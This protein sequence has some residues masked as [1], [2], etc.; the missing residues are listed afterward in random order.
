[1]A[2]GYSGTPLVQKLGIKP[3]SRMRVVNAPSHYLQL[4]GELPAGV[5]FRRATRGAL[6]FVHYFAVSQ[7]DLLAKLPTLKQHLS[8]TGVLWISWPKR[9]SALAH[10]VSE[11]IVREAGLNTGLVD[12]K[13]CAVDEDWS[14]LKFVWRLK[15]R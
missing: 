5:R 1:M 6:D 10:N 4:L 13:I 2:A 14:G 11:S 15:D 12:V 3:G 8:P 7:R 9:T